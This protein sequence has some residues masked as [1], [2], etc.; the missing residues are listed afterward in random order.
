ML[1]GSY[2]YLCE[3]DKSL[4]MAELIR[5]GEAGYARDYRLGTAFGSNKDALRLDAFT[6]G[7]FEVL[8]DRLRCRDDSLRLLTY[9]H[10]LLAL[11]PGDAARRGLN[12]MCSLNSQQPLIRYV[13]GGRFNGLKL[14]GGKAPEIGLFAKLLADEIE[15]R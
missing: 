5:A 8:A 3:V 12:E 6:F 10:K 9:L 11:G 1:A 2:T 7:L 13:A 14:L 4:E 15:S